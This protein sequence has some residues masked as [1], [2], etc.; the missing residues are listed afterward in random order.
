MTAQAAPVK[1]VV[2][3][4]VQDLA[5]HLSNFLDEFEGQW[6]YQTMSE[7]V[8]TVSPEFA[9]QYVSA[10]EYMT[11]SFGRSFSRV[12]DVKNWLNEL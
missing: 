10:A 2:H 9:E 5:T 4:T 1:S 11:K 7:G 8:I 3:Q 6:D 12:D